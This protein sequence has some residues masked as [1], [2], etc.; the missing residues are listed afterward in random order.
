MVV[1]NTVWKRRMRAGSWRTLT[2]KNWTSEEH[3]ELDE[4]VLFLGGDLVPPA[5][6]ATLFNLLVGDAL[7]DIDIEPFLWHD[8]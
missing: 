4:Q 3:Q 1:L 8:N 2:I 5:A 7:L 6:S